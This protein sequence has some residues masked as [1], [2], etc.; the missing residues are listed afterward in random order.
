MVETLAKVIRVAL[1]G[2]KINRETERDRQAGSETDRK[3][4]V[5]E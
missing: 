2:R 1:G 3:R 4:C 5:F